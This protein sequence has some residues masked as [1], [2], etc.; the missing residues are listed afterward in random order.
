MHL[1]GSLL[2]RSISERS[3]VDHGIE[4][5][6]GVDFHVEMTS[7]SESSATLSCTRGPVHQNNHVAMG[8]LLAL[9]QVFVLTGERY[10]SMSLTRPS[11]TPAGKYTESS[12]GEAFTLWMSQSP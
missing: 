2:N 5:A 7:Q 9:Y 10:S 3:V 11:L 4:Q 12:G 1:G 8:Y 6:K